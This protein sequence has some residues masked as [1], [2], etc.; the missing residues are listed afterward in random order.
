MLGRTSM[1]DFQQQSANQ[2]AQAWCAMP[3]LIDSGLNHLQQMVDDTLGPAENDL[4]AAANVRVPKYAL[5][6]ESTDYLRYLSVS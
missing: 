4:K 2:S 6:A 5:I 3:L 1:K